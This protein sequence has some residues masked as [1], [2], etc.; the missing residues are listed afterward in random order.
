MLG[1]VK[2]SSRVEE[3]RGDLGAVQPSFRFLSPLIEPD[4]RI[5]RIRLSKRLSREGMQRVTTL[6]P[7]AELED[8]SVVKDALGRE[9]P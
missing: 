5:S 8:L 1:L 6:R 9:Q 7:A 2:N 4:V 3:R